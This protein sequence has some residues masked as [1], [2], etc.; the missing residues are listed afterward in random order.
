MSTITP[1]AAPPRPRLD[2]LGWDHP[3]GHRGRRSR[4]R[5]FAAAALVAVGGWLAAVAFLSVGS[6]HQVLALARPVPRYHALAASDLH[7]VRVAADAEVAT[8]PAAH[9]DQLVGRLTATELAAGSLLD[10]RSLL[11][12]DTRP[13]HDDEAVVGAL[14]TPADAPEQLSPG[15][16]LR[17]IVRSVAGSDEPAHTFSGWMLQVEA[18]GPTSNGARRASLVVPASGAGEVSAAAAD[19]RV[20]IVVLGG[21]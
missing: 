18:A 6:R 15:A 9:L 10:E 12:P 7:V 20:S 13:V 14:L 11:A 3:P 4:A 5:L 2:A 8:A 19:G 1:N 17:I 16:L 21:G